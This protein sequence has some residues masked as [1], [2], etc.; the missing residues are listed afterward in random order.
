MNI[1]DSN[2]AYVEILRV[3]VARHSYLKYKF[4][5]TIN[6]FFFAKKKEVK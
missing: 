3:Q 2:V 5:H 1:N 4:M 6:I